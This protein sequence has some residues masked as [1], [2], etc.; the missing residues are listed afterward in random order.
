[1]WAWACVALLLSVAMAAPSTYAEAMRSSWA[2]EWVAQGGLDD[3][4]IASLDSPSQS[5][6]PL[7]L[8]ASE[9]LVRDEEYAYEEALEGEPWE[10]SRELPNEFLW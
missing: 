6:Q 1:M 9:W 10:S 5:A 4:L 8:S 2:E 3:E 7:D